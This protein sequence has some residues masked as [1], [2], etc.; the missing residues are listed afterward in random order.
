MVL[1]PGK[2]VAP[3]PVLLMARELNQGG[4]ERQVTEIA[5]ALDRTRF[6]PHVGCFYDSGW[7]ADE[8]R[9]AG[10]P[11]QR[12]P[13][14]SYVGPSA[15]TGG[16][17]LIRDIRRK[18]IRIVHTFDYPLAAYAVPVARMFTSAAVLAS[19]RAH[20]SLIP[21]SYVKLLRLSDRLACAVVVNCEFVRQ[22]LIRE[23]H[24]PP[25][26]IRLCYNGLDLSAFRPLGI[27]R[28]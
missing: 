16:W 17:Q 8:L 5:R 15:I 11:I 24:V 18:R 1:Y 19:Q 28:P 13:I 3:L 2:E 14:T 6:E 22:H 21:P 9:R 4:S 26:R 10:I 27:S 25:E 7:R 23:E 20:R 12:F